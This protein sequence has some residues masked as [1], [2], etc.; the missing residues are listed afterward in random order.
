VGAI[1]QVAM[2]LADLI[3]SWLNPRLRLGG[4]G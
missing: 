3:Y 4:H 1:F 2:L